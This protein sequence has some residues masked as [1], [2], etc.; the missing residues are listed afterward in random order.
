MALE[1]QSRSGFSS[2]SSA[3]PLVDEEKRAPGCLLEC[4]VGMLGNQWVRINGL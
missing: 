1:L 4:P 3:G 2:S